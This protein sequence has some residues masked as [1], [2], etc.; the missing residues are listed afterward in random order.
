[1]EKILVT[2]ATGYVGKRLILQLLGLGYEVYALCYIKGI[3][4]FEEEKP[5]LHYIWGDLR[6]EETLKNLP[7]DLSAAYYLVHSM[8]E[9]VN[10]ESETDVLIAKNFIQA[11]EKTNTKQIIYL[12]STLNDEEHPSDYLKSRLLVEN[13]LKS[14]KIPVTVLRASII[15][16]AGSAAF[17]VIRDLVEKMSIIASPKWVDNKCQPIAIIDVLFY[18]TS[19]L[20][21]SESFNKTYDIG[22]DQILSFKDLMQ[23]YADFRSLKRLIF[24]ANFLPQRFSTYWFV[25]MSTV[26]YS[27]CR[28]LIEILKSDTLVKEGNINELFKHNCLTYRQS[29]ELAFQKIDQNAVVSTWMDSWDLKSQDPSISNYI[30]VPK[31]GCLKDVRKVFVKDGK[32]K[33]IERIWK[34]GGDK[35]YYAMDWAWYLRGLFDQFIGGV[36][37]NRGR[38]HPSEII[39]GDSIDFWRVLKADKNKGHLI[40]WATMKVPGDAWLEFHLENID[41]KWM[42]LQ[43]A[44]FRPSGIFGRLYWWSMYPFHLYIFAKMAKTIAGVTPIKDKP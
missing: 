14:S 10:K 1:M 30:E 13:T 28:Y 40:L 16:G 33:T 21:K 22:G 8:S 9:V 34:I 39:P 24:T 5:H 2:G 43:T 38:R 41:N 23:G 20:F 32:E 42:L 31:D 26:S 37:L 11:L 7:I 17:E 35:G 6:N 25:F 19:I 3:K 18:L 36:G 4:A 15:I 27:I 44:T 12:G 29:L